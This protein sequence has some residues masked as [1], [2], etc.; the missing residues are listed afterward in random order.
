VFEIRFQEEREEDDES[1]G[2]AGIVLL[3]P[4]GNAAALGGVIGEE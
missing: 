1:L 4:A 2:I 3:A